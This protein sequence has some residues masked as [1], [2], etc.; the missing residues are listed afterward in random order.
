MDSY[1]IEKHFRQDLQDNQDFLVCHFPEEN[2]KTQCASGAS[3]QLII[4]LPK[5]AYK[6]FI[7]EGDAVSRLSSGRPGK[8]P[9]NPVN[10][11]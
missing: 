7:A 9:V 1:L 4:N 11:V 6:V 5:F 8:N 3:V 2:D 10:P